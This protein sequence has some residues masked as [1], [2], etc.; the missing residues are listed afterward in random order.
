MCTVFMGGGEGVGSGILFLFQK[1]QFPRR[2]SG[3]VG[4]K[5]T[6]GMIQ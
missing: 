5:P 6:F 3:G 1:Q 2:V 4:A